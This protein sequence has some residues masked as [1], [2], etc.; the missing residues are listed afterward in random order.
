MLYI[1]YMYPIPLIKSLLEKREIEYNGK[2]YKIHSNIKLDE[3][4]VLYNLII[5][6]NL[7]HTLEIG[8]ATG[9]SSLFIGSAIKQIDGNHIA[10]DPFQSTQWEN[11]GM[12][13][14]RKAG[15]EKYISL[16]E[17]K[18]YI[19]LPALLLK[20]KF[21]LIFIDGWHTFDYTLVDFF[22]SDLMLHVGGYIIIDDIL[23]KGV[24]KFTKYLLSNY[25]H[26]EEVKTNS[27]TIIV[28]KKIRE[29]DRKWYFHKEF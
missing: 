20:H 18:S 14:I 11:L 3:G 23:H 6:H 4:M 21:N 29:D 5:Q 13:N 26:Y 12:M 2:K 25:K 7:K 1:L 27:R 16:I 19:A 8:M 24:S 28:V 17:Q 22:Y 15:L 9:I 10:I